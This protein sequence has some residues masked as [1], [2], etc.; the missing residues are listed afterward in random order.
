MYSH[1]SQSAGR[2]V[3]TM[4]CPR[5]LFPTLSLLALLVI[6]SSAESGVKTCTTITH[7]LDLDELVRDSNVLV[8]V[9]AD[10]GETDTEDE[11]YN[12]LCDRLKA[13]PIDRVQHLIIGKIV[14]KAFAD[15]L[16]ESAKPDWWSWV[17]ETVATKAF[18][19]DKSTRPQYML[20]RKAGPLQPG[21]LYVG[22]KSADNVSDFLS[23]ALKI[24]RIG[25][26]VY[27]LGHLDFIAANLVR[28]KKN[29]DHP[30]KQKAWA[31]TAK[32]ITT[33]MSISATG[34]SP[35][36]AA[37]YVKT[38]FAILD[39]GLA[40]PENQVERLER[41]LQDNTNQIS[42]LQKENLH[43]KVYTMK[44]FT[45][46]VDV[47]DKEIRNFIL[48]SAMNVGL[49]LALLILIPLM[50]F[51]RGEEDDHDSEDKNSTSKE[52]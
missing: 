10:E 34:S 4:A 17:K 39:R 42:A 32:V 15:T 46:P 12:E 50:F 38:C 43:Q 30:W 13:T 48:H 37:L 16:L 20:F 27:S 25:N 6:Y 45:D 2:K 23:S 3:L 7:Q 52:D 1:K 24:K 51:S 29:D 21:W 35:E 33:M 31:Y 49:L 44:K 14:D 28:A 40:Y 22:E 8:Y 19:M 18:S 11:A 26:F 47:G 9:G 41:L 5:Y 36:V